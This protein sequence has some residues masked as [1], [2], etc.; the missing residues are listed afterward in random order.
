MAKYKKRKLKKMANKN[1]TKTSMLSK[2]KGLLVA[3]KYQFLKHSASLMAIIF[4]KLK[5]PLPHLY[6]FYFITYHATGHNAMMNFLAYCGVSLNHDWQHI[7]GF[8]RYERNYKRLLSVRTNCALALCEYN[9]KDFLKYTRL[10]NAKVPALLL[11]RDPIS[12]LKSC[13]NFISN[14]N[15]Q[16]IGGEQTRLLEYL[17]YGAYNPITKERYFANSPCLDTIEIMITQFQDKKMDTLFTL[18]IF[19]ALLSAL[20]QIT[21][22][23]YVDMEEI[24]PSKAFTTMQLLSQKFGFPPP[25]QEDKPLFERQFYAQ[26]YCIFPLTLVITTQDSE[27]KLLLTNQKNTKGIDMTETLMPSSYQKNP[28]LENCKVFVKTHKETQEISKHFAQV[29]TELIATLEILLQFVESKKSKAL[30]EKDILEYFASHPKLAKEFK[31]I[32]DQDLQDL[33]VQRPDI[34]E[35][36]KNYQAFIKIC[37]ELD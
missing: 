1:N 19:D 33:K 32:C 29:S 27:I 20:P 8:E 21:Q 17:R 9:F 14:E 18:F 25:K 7:N 35:S 34:I 30:S 3:L 5:T 16:I 31:A 2:A 10:L 23:H 26:L 22:K 4:Y 28:N 12:I 6:Q 24:K 37:E 15:T 13:I 11:V 36:W